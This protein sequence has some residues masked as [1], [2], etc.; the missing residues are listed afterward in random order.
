MLQPDKRKQLD[1]NIRKMLENGASPDDVK[2][3]A[4]DFKSKY[5][6]KKESS[7]L[8]SDGPKLDSEAKDTNGL[9][10]SPQTSKPL[11]DYDTQLDQLEEGV[12][13]SQN[14]VSKKNTENKQAIERNINA[15]NEL[16][17]FEDTNKTELE[18]AEQRKTFQS[19]L[20]KDQPQEVVDAYN[21]FTQLDELNE[22]ALV[23]IDQKISEEKK[24]D[25]GILSNAWNT[26]KD[27][28]GYSDDRKVSDKENLIE[29][30]IEQ[31][32]IDFLNEL[33]N[34]EIRKAV[35]NIKLQERFRADQSLKDNELLIQ[36][37]ALKSNALIERIRRIDDNQKNLIKGLETEKNPETRKAILEEVKKNE[38]EFKI[39]QG[40]ITKI[41]SEAE[42]LIENIETN[43]KN[44][45]TFND[46][47]ELLKRNYQWLDV[48]KET[49][50]LGVADLGNSI[51]FRLNTIKTGINERLPF[52]DKITEE[53]KAQNK[54][55]EK[56]ALEF[57]QFTANQ[58][59]FLEPKL[60]VSQIESIPD[61]GKFAI[62]STIENIPT[63][64][65][66][67]G[68]RVGVGSFFVSQQASEELDI[69]QGII[70]DKKALQQYNTILNNPQQRKN[71]STKEISDME[72]Q[73]A[74]ILG[75]RKLTE[76]DIATMSS[77]FAASE[78]ALGYLG[79][80][81][82]INKGK[83][84]AQ[85]IG[86]QELKTVTKQSILQNIGIQS[87]DLVKDAT[88]EGLEELGTGTL[89][90]IVEIGYVGDKIGDDGKERTLG[91][92]AIDNFVGGFA[93]GSNLSG[94][95]KA[96]G[97]ALGFVA[98]KQRRTQVAENTLEAIK[99]LQQSEIPG[100]T[101]AA[102]DVL[103][104]KANSLYKDNAKIINATEEQFKNLNPKDKA[105]VRTINNEIQS[106]NLSKSKIKDEASAEL[107]ESRLEELDNEKKAVLDNETIP[108][109]KKETTTETEQ[110]ALENI[111]PKT[112]VESEEVETNIKT[113]ENA[114]EK[115]QT[116]TKNTEEVK[117]Q[118][119]E[120]KKAVLNETQAQG[121]TVADA[122]V[123][124]RVEP[125]TEQEQ[126]NT[127]QPTVN[128]KPSK[129]EVEAKP[130]TITRGKNNYTVS[131]DKGVITV[132][133]KNGDTPSKT[134]Q[135]E[136][137]KEYA[138]QIDLTDGNRYTPQEGQTTGDIDTEI[139]NNSKNPSELAEVALRTK[140]TDFIEENS[141]SEAIEVIEYVQQNVNRDSFINISDKNNITNA[142]GRSYFNKNG[143][144]LD[145]LAQELSEQMGREITEKDIVDIMLQ[146][147]NG[148]NDV[149]KEVRDKYSNPAKQR[150]TELTGLPASDYYLEKAVNQAKEKEKLNIELDKNYLLNL[151]DAE[152]MALDQERIDYEEA[153][154]Q[155][156]KSRKKTKNPKNSKEQSGVRENADAKKPTKQERKQIAFDKIDNIAEK[157]KDALPGIKDS[158]ININGFSQDQLID[159]MAQSVKFLVG[160]G[161]EVNAAIKQVVQSIKDKFNVDINPDDVRSILNE[162]NKKQ[163]AKSDKRKK[164][165]LTKAATGE[166]NP[167]VRA[168]LKKHGLDYKVESQEEAK[169][170]AEAFVKDIGVDAAINAIKS[171]EIQPGAELAFIYSEV[172]DT[173][174][175]QI[176]SANTKEQAKL[177]DTYTKLQEDIFI[178]LDNDAREFGRFISALRNVYNSSYFKYNL[179]KQIEAYK[180][181]NYGEIDAET[182]KRFKER[183]A[184]IKAFEQQI[185][186]LEQK[187]EDAEAQQAVDDI[188]ESVGRENPKPRATRS[189]LKKAAKVLRKAK[190]TKSISDLSNLQSNPI[191]VVQGVWDGAIEVV[192]QALDAGSTIELAVKKGISHIKKSDWY[193]SLNKENK[194]TVENRFKNDIESNISEEEFEVTINEDGTLNIP[195]GLIRQYVANGYTEITKLT[196][197]IKND[198]LAD[199]D[200]SLREVRDAI[201]GY[202]KT[203]NPTKD[204][205]SEEIS[206]L[207]NLGRVL[208][209]ME[210]VS[211]GQR[212]KRSGYQRRKKTDEERRKEKQLKE[213]M[214]DLPMDEADI[215]KQ[216]KSQLDNVK[217]RLK[218]QI[219]DLNEQIKN[220]EKSKPE[221]RPIAYDQEAK[222]LQ[223]LR[224]ELK[225][226]L[227]NIV[228]KEELSYEDRV[229][230]AENA[231]ERSIERLEKDIA[232]N[233]IAFK[234][235][236]SVTSAKI[237]QLKQKQAD[238]KAELDQIRKDS[239]LT[240]ARRLKQRKKAV[241]KRLAELQEKRKNKDYSKKKREPLPEDKELKELK[242]KYEKEKEKYDQEAYEHELRNMPMHKKLFKQAV[243]FL[244]LQRVLLT[245]GEGSFVFL[246]NAAPTVNLLV[247]NPRKLIDI[248]TKTIKSYSKTNFDNDYAELENNDLF[249]LAK[250]SKL[251]LT[252]TSFKMNAKEEV[253]QSDV[254]SSLFKVLGNTIDPKG[255]SKL[256]LFNSV[257][258]V[259]G[260]DVSNK[261]RI[262]V[263]DQIQNANPFDAMERFTTTYGNLIKMDL[264]QKG[265]K[266][267]EIEGKNPI[268]NKKDYERL[269]NAIN[270]LT[271]RANLGRFDSIT[272]ELNA[273][274]FS[275]RFA[276]STFNKLNPIYYAGVLRDSESNKPSV[277]QKMIVS[278]MITYVATTTSFI[279]AIQALGGE[280]EDGNNIVE[281]ETNPTSSD[282]GKLKIG[283]IRFD[284][285][286]GHMP[287]INLISRIATGKFKKSNGKVV[288]LG[289]GSNP[290]RFD[291]LV[292]FGVGKANPTVA[293]GIRFMR[294]N[295]EIDGTKRDIYGNEVSIEEEVKKMYPIYWQGI[296][297]VIEEDPK[298]GKEIAFFMTSLGLMGINNQV[299]GSNPKYL[300][301]GFSKDTKNEMNYK[302]QQFTRP[303][304]EEVTSDKQL[305]QSFNAFKDKHEE[306][307]IALIKRVKKDR[308][309][310][311][312]R[313]IQQLLKSGGLSKE[314]V[315]D[316]MIGRIP[317]M[318][319]I[320]ISSLNKKL[321]ELEIRLTKKELKNIDII[322]KDMRKKALFYN[323]NAK[324]YNL[325]SRF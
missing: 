97:N 92:S 264:F 206:K 93:V 46:E 231:L 300:L 140:Q 50:R 292:D 302:R 35:A 214:R 164:S 43:K 77:T 177:E 118:E 52:T 100:L 297:E 59:E 186:D 201:T 277:A 198:Y 33:D 225:T 101:T 129:T 181:R 311:S 170:K 183:D 123:Q 34:P 42:T 32:R 306:N 61:F 150:F 27:F 189:S 265:V 83:R 36:N 99:L 82:L 96:V 105:K 146:Y 294:A 112:E 208:S 276:A 202:G 299:Y 13:S 195:K 182:L 120:N 296:K 66:F 325:K 127:A 39:Y 318:T 203:I 247:R 309:T 75:K 16:Y 258:K 91:D 291:K 71:Y 53:G 132:T 279:L 51:N 74:N 180:A 24:G 21:S 158:D 17:A 149:K 147:P 261:K 144:G 70:D 37:K 209:G 303:N 84:V 244:G 85:S 10:D 145:V 106:L 136:V 256:T 310:M 288:N 22:E 166:G 237:K 26:T 69:K 62:E 236:K 179:E 78:I 128:A 133:N 38:K 176:D 157:L 8:T 253:F 289:E 87:W 154:N 248:F 152:L 268:D 254:V 240:E 81:R 190:F 41:Q 226:I 205:L 156:P 257:K 116:E 245:T 142:V 80:I 163:S 79:K 4:S 316:I 304:K 68:R 249:E 312:L 31:N 168:A 169:A 126:D 274:F 95:T 271:G 293:T 207:K 30:R 185:K 139:A 175:Q 18:Q 301:K 280:D 65:Q 227:E 159:L 56:K 218:N 110:Q 49:L 211:K 102:K 45:G 308:A 217:S 104:N 107:I 3:Y 90:N 117:N 266:K 187:L 165:V 223:E 7:E 321:N 242:R 40:E 235:N 60:E 167:K 284:P 125:R 5:E 162:P 287:W 171:G 232:A 319:E 76:L 196:E 73:R 48:Q 161:I 194:K 283:N 9:L 192:A 295:E 130:V 222:E 138:D 314:S 290:T 281:I 260:V 272:P 324:M 131:K 11:D 197:V 67:M 155:R 255:K 122:D 250:K 210:D 119:T 230:R 153:T 14:L 322:K 54:E 58:R 188:S 121:N 286:G 263:K 109:S 252:R 307:Y 28:F 23:E 44:L 315:L 313:E 178:K 137:L 229:K 1:S 113:E 273:M 148:I 184:K 219:S 213:A 89:K 233:N 224:D 285:W 270:T 221:R 200:V 216:F 191:G 98:N 243:N 57:Q 88:G 134:T 55:A 94:T 141:D 320:K 151:T 29:K 317:K 239:G 143:R 173:L 298:K 234:E 199:E 262:A 215:T 174:E 172:I 114:Q 63:L 135:R 269:A 19:N 160:T 64:L 2:T 72:R 103:L 86:Q 278:Q 259:L 282:F 193:K 228:G 15:I 115:I 212:P 275:A 305:Q 47:L 241:E 204:E 246:Q 25:F 108:K 238:L 111:T 323:K 20:L 6:K 267:L 12:A 124:P 251:A 220:K